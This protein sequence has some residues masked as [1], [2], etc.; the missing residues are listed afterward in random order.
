MWDMR[1]EREITEREEEQEEQE[2]KREKFTHTICAS[3]VWLCCIHDA[4]LCDCF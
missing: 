1:D 4:R 2:G 3:K